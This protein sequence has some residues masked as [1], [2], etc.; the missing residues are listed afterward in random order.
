[1]KRHKIR[2]RDWMTPEPYTILPG[3]LL[4]DAYILIKEQE[5]HRLP[6]VT[7]GDEL[8]GIVTF[9][10]ILQHIPF[11]PDDASLELELPLLRKSVH[12]IMTWDPITV[13]PDDT[14][15]VA[16]ERMLEYEISGLP[17][18][19]E[20]DGCLVGIITESDIF[21]LVVQSWA[22]EEDV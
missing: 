14:I 6:V 18:V 22:D 1:M 20:E 13:S 16:A 7:R 9:S 4:N 2:I 11:F 21:R 5:I 15:Q 3:A 8:V 10:D 12:E 19:R 17:V